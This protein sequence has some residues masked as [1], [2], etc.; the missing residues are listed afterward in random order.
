MDAPNPPLRCEDSKVLADEEKSRFADALAARELDIGVF[1][2]FEDLARRSTDAERFF[3]VKVFDDSGLVGVGLVSRVEHYNPYHALNTRYRRF[4]VLEPLLR[5]SRVFGG[6]VMYCAMNEILGANL[7]GPVYCRDESRRDTVKAAIAAHLKNKPDAAYVVVIDDVD[8][9]AVYRGRG[10][11]AFPYCSG[12]SIRASRYTSIDDYFAVHNRTRKKLA[13]FRRRQPVTVEVTRGAVGDDVREA[14]GRCLVSS[15]RS[16]RSVIPFQGFFDRHILDTEPFRREA[17][18][19]ILVRL[20]GTL[21]GFSTFRQCGR[22][23][24]GILGGFDR[25]YTRDAPVYDLLVASALEYALTEGLESVHFGIV[26]NYTKARLTDSFDPLRFYFWSN[27]WLYRKLQRW[28]YFV[29]TP[30]ELHA[31]ERQALGKD[32]GDREK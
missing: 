11:A 9:E 5:V 4:R 10:Y 8:D 15:A 26:N 29:W 25:R 17:Y 28:L 31:F 16:T 27:N 18:V 13:K 20:D 6:N 12:A 3:F 7:D 1:E 23:L 21:A 22:R 24:G 19:H 2:F 32:A 14:M 30:H